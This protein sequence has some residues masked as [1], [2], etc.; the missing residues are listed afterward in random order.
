MSDLNGDSLKETVLALARKLDDKKA[1]GKVSR[2]Q[3]IAEAAGKQS[4]RNGNKKCVSCMKLAAWT[5]TI[6]SK[7]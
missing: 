5:T 3:G 7:E 1:S 6:D 4:K 2:W